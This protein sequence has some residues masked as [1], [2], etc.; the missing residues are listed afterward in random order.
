MTVSL[1]VACAYGCVASTPGPTVPDIA[2]A[3][4]RLTGRGY[5]ER[6]IVPCP[7]CLAARDVGAPVSEP[8]DDQLNL[9]TEVAA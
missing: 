2:A 7:G 3:R 4:G 9:F 8:T 6:A 1:T 5:D